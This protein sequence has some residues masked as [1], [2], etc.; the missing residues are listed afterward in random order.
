MTVLI[1]LLEEPSA[2]VFLECITKRLGI[3][4][5]CNFFV[6]NGKSDLE[7]KVTLRLQGWKIPNSYFLIMRDR[8]SS[9]CKRTKNF[10]L[11]QCRASNIPETF[12]KVRI[13]C[14]ELESFYLGDLFAV[15]RAYNKP[16]LSQKQ[17]NRKFRNPDSLGNACQ[18]FFKLVDSPTRKMQAAKLIGEVIE[19][20]HYEQNKS[21]SFRCLIKT[22][23]EFKKLCLSL[24]DKNIT[25]AEN[26]DNI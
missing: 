26:I 2:K 19:L 4:Y 7:N 3:Y 23:L 12:F 20:D 16:N 15:S 6:F 5:L 10:L 18:E 17:N 13:A 11:E 22:L 25:I 8:D 14:G 21:I 1:F 9:D 24:R